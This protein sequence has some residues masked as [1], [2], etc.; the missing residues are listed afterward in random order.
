M[1]QGD[2]DEGMENEEDTLNAQSRAK[3]KDIYSQ[4]INILGKL[5]QIY[6]QGL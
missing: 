5:E 4:K 2:Q 3:S 6:E 1:M